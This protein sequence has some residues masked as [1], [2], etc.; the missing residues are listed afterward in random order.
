MITLKDLAKELKVSISTVSKALSDSHEISKETKEKIVAF[1]KSKNY[2]P[3]TTAI[4]LRSRKTNTIG[5]II[6]NIF[7]HFYTKILSGVEKEAK[8]NG[9]KIVVAIS[10]EKL[11]SEKEGISFFSNGSVDGILLAPSDETEKSNNFKHILE[12]QNRNIPFVFFDRYFEEIKADKVII[13]DF[14]SAKNTVQYFINS[15]R[16]NILLVSLLKNLRI[17]KFRKEGALSATKNLKVLEFDTEN[18]LEL[19]VKK[20]LKTKEFDAIFALDELSGIISLN[21]TRVLEFS[22]PKDV[23]IISFSQG[24]LSEYSYPKLSTINQHA[25]SIGEKSLQLLLK[26]FNSKEGGGFVTEVITTNLEI[27][28]T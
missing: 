24:V 11:E 8:K 12:L 17:G 1:A 2:V 14:D 6:P 9:Y 13:N 21:L 20:A 10:N 25:E 4:N 28:Q 23:S 16:K 22:I 18:D 7:N 19:A 26:R 3:N 15:G 5:V 27:N